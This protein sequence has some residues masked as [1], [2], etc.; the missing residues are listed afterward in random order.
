MD[1]NGT[2]CFCTNR[3]DASLSKGISSRIKEG[4]AHQETNVA[5]KTGNELKD[6][7]K[8]RLPQAS[9]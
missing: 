7:A 3:Y 8:P 1:W 6:Q 2:L 5:Q 4:K 9:S